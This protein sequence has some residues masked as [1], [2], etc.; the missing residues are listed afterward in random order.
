MS[1]LKIGDKVYLN[2]ESKCISKEDLKSLQGSV[3]TIVATSGAWV[4]VRWGYNED[5]IFRSYH[6][7]SLLKIE[8]KLKEDK[9]LPVYKTGQNVTPKS[10]DGEILTG[11]GVIISVEESKYSV[12]YKVL[13]DFGNVV[14]LTEG[15]FHTYYEVNSEYVIDI[16]ERIQIQMDKLTNAWIKLK[17]GDYN[18]QSI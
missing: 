15:D 4:D 8:L 6:P 12:L 10:V 17:D 1:D 18:G 3:G 14:T 13:T 5:C 9:P 2:P 16:E 11:C 7:L